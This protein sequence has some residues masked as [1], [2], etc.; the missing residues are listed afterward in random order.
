MNGV[1]FDCIHEF[2]IMLVTIQEILQRA[3]VTNIHHSILRGIKQWIV[4][5]SEAVVRTS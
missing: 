5:T 3:R 4:D 2:F 1:Q